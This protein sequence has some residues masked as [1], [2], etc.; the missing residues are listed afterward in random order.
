LL[1]LSQRRCVCRPLLPRLR[2]ILKVRLLEP[3]LRRPLR[4]PRRL[5]WPERC[6]LP[7]VSPSFCSICTPLI[8]CVPVL[9]A[10]CLLRSCNSS[11]HS[12][13]RNMS[14]SGCVAD[15]DC[16]I[17]TYCD[18]DNSPRT[19]RST[20]PTGSPCNA[21]ATSNV[22][23]GGGYCMPLS[24]NPASSAGKCIAPNSLPSDDYKEYPAPYADQFWYY[25]SLYGHYY[26][27]SGLGVPVLDNSTAAGYPKAAFSCAAVLNWERVGRPCSSCA[28][29]DAANTP[30]ACRVLWH[31]LLL[32]EITPAS[33]LVPA[34]SALPLRTAELRKTPLRP[35]RPE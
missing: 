11:T 20:V 29:R 26:C 6:C 27:A 34:D 8:N 31:F 1:L 9:I 19:C 25:A 35:C 23:A 32:C 18:V 14:V 30:S 15:G 13:T 12:C 17:S 33:R 24:S 28:W 21:S 3:L 5:P 4:E 7:R 2:V 16:S 10:P 22:C